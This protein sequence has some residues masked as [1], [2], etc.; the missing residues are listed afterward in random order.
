MARG[1]PL[2]DV[3][4]A[5]IRTNEAN[6]LTIDWEFSGFEGEALLSEPLQLDMKP[7]D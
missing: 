2:I 7:N 1:Q 5:E 3:R 6:S 4:D